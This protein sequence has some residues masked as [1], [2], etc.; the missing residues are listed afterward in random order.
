MYYKKYENYV[1]QK[2]ENYILQKKVKQTFDCLQIMWELLH[3]TY[4][5]NNFCGVHPVWRCVDMQF[6]I[7][8]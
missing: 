8:V 2:Y 4:K 5:T 6:K 3:K 1:A 7:S